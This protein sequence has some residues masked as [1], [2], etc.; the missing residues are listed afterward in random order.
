MLASTV[1]RHG[2]VQVPA[3]AEVYCVLDDP[4]CGLITKFRHAGAD[5][6]A[7]SA[8]EA[9]DGSTSFHA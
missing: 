1:E 6:G 7:L 9:F 2:P 8:F 4:R 3:Q 5:P